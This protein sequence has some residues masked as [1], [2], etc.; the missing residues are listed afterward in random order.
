MYTSLALFALS[1]V[2]APSAVSAEPAWIRDYGLARKQ[3]VSENKPLAVFVGSGKKGWEQVSQEGALG[4]NVKQVLAENYVCVYLD[5]DQQAGRKLAGAFEFSEG[6]GLVLSSRKGALQ[7]FR[8]E[9]ELSNRELA[10]YLT[11]F[12]DP[13]QVVR[14]TETV[15]QA[16]P[17]YISYYQAP[18]QPVVPVMYNGGFGGGFGGGFA[19]S[20][21]G[22][23][24]G[25][26]GC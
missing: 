19:P 24:G 10:R 22:G 6:P 17:Q 7:A 13:E 11:R 21:M 9:G 16:P 26:G 8:H 23:G 15:P 18:V 12:S 2:F 20:F 14:H 25:R 1:G 4:K 3:G 5:T